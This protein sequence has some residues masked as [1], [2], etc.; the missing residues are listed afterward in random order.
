VFDTHKIVQ[1]WRVHELL[2]Y[3]LGIQNKTSKVMF[4]V[5]VF[6]ATFNNDSVIAWWSVLLSK[7][8]LENHW[9]RNTLPSATVFLFYIFTFLMLKEPNKI[10][11]LTIISDS[12]LYLAI[13]RSFKCHKCSDWQ[14]PMQSVPMII[15]NKKI[16]FGS[17]SIKKVKI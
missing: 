10:F 14:L 5:M 7:P 16:L 11:L 2:K 6:N 15:V 8:E 12:R 4:G 17:L 1:N 9:L 13:S 3:I